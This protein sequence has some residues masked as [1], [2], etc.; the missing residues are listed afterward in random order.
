VRLV[1]VVLAALGVVRLALLPLVVLERALQLGAACARRLQ[2]RVSRARARKL[3][4]DL[5]RP[6]VI[7]LEQLWSAADGVLTLKRVRLGDQVVR[8]GVGLTVCVHEGGAI[9][10]Q[11][12]PMHQALDVVAEVGGDGGE[13]F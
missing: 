3:A 11:A 1:L 5:G 13:V 6:L 8:G 2:I 10:L 12:L 9:G 4:G 7:P